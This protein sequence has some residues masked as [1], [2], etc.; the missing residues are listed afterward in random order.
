M[1]EGLYTL[2]YCSNLLRDHRGYSV[3]AKCSHEKF[4]TCQNKTVYERSELPVN[5]LLLHF[6]TLVHKLI[7]LLS[8][9]TLT[10][11]II[12]PYVYIDF[13]A[14]DPIKSSVLSVQK[15]IPMFK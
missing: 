7:F 13:N 10:V 5:V 4:R 14:S 9:L 6:H 11:S 8:I 12:L 3:L 2:V 15:Y 1:F